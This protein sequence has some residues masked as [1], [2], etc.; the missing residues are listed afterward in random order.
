MKI[1]LVKQKGKWRWAA[2]PLGL[3]GMPPIGQGKTRVLAVA[4]LFLHL[5]YEDNT[6][7]TNWLSNEQLQ[8]VEIV[9]NDSKS[10]TP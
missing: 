6:E 10:D 4:S 5:L 3:P 1:K 8:S 7:G 2:E 9:R